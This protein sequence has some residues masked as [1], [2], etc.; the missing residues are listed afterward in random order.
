MLRALPVRNPE[1]L[2]A[3]VRTNGN[4]IQEGFTYQE[5]HVMREYTQMVELAA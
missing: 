1:T 3:V 5:Y 2:M 4:A